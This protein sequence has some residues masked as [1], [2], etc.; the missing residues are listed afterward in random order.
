MWAVLRPIVL[1][2][3]VALPAVALL[4]VAAEAFRYTHAES[5]LHAYQDLIAGMLALFGALVGAAYLNRQIVVQRE[6][7]LT[8]QH[9]RHA[10]ARAVMPHAL[11]SLVNYAS[12]TAAGLQDARLKEEELVAFETSTSQTADVAPVELPRLPDDLTR[13][14]A[15]MIEASEESEA[16]PFI[17][18]LSDLQVQIARVNELNSAYELSKQNHELRSYELLFRVWDA[19]YL[20]A[21]AGALFAYARRQPGVAPARPDWAMV[22]N[23]MVNLKL[24]DLRDLSELVARKRQRDLVPQLVSSQIGS[25]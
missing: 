20:H 12:D 3:A 21:A 24:F 16:R 22:E 7:E 19:V 1:G 23:S 25:D 5:L 18:L 13:A 6:Q 14:F 10:A 9:R 2:C 11:M 17:D 4:F 8:R 15:A